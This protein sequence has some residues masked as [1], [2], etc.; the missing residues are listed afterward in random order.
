MGSLRNT[1]TPRRYDSEPAELPFNKMKK[2]Y[3]YNGRSEK[4]HLSVIANLVAHS[5]PVI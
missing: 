2:A 4:K 3:R 1:A 5:Q